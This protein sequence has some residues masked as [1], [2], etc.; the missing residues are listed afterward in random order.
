VS[1]DRPCVRARS[2]RGGQK[3]R[4][5]NAASPAYMWIRPLSRSPRRTS[6][7]FISTEASSLPRA[8][9]WRKRTRD[10]VRAVGGMPLSRLP[11]PT[12][13]ARYVRDRDQQRWRRRVGSNPL[14]PTIVVSSPRLAMRREE[15]GPSRPSP[16]SRWLV[17]CV[18][19]PPGAPLFPRC[20]S[21]PILAEASNA[22]FSEWRRRRQPM[23]QMPS[24]SARIVRCSP[25]PN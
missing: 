23:C 13:V 11:D 14:G 5:D 2:A 20:S 17:E 8:A 18:R 12:N 16:R 3:P 4:F 25:R 15:P 7:E 1:P 9:Q 22:S 21:S 24:P 19:T 10:L 6:G